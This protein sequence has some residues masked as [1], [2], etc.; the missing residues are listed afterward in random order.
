MSISSVRVG[1][2]LGTALGVCLIH[3][4]SLALTI[5]EVEPNDSFATAQQ[6]GRDLFSLD[7]VQAIGDSPDTNTSTLIPHVSILGTGNDSEDFYSFSAPVWLTL[8]D[9][10]FTS[11][12][13]ARIELYDSSQTLLLFSED[14]AWDST[15][16]PGRGIFTD[17]SSPDQSESWFLDPFIAATLV[18]GPYFLKVE[19]LEDGF[20]PDGAVYTLHISAPAPLPVLGIGAAFG[21]SRKLRRRIK[22][23]QAKS[24]QAS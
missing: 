13:D 6:I 18:E 1:A 14:F 17:G 2:L 21:V 4:S 9:I 20:V 15:A 3:A 11:N 24:L 10:D 16:I 23:S 12:L 7:Y 5:D 8:L 19:T 22:A